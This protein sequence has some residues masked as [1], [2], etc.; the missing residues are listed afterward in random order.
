[1][2]ITVINTGGTFNKVYN[3]IKGH[4]EIKFDNSSL[5]NIIKY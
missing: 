2:K 4:L 5:F 1:M 3:T